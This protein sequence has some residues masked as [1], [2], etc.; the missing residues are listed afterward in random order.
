MYSDV[1]VR[2]CLCVCVCLISDRQLFIGENKNCCFL[3]SIRLE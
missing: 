1:C 2:E 3:S